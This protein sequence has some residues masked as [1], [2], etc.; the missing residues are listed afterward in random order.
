MPRVLLVEVASDQ[1]ATDAAPDGAK[2]PAAQGVSQQRTAS[3]AR[4]RANGSVAA[5]AAAPTVVVPVTIIPPVVAMVAVILRSY[6]G[7]QR[8]R[9]GRERQERCCHKLFLHG[10]CSIDGVTVGGPEDARLLIK[11]RLRTV[12]QD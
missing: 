1:S 2:R 4:N 11:D 8:N 5:A 6:R 12:T 10:A 9:C 3:T 7:G